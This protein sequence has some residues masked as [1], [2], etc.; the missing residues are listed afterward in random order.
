MRFKSL[1]AGPFIY[2]HKH[3]DEM[4]IIKEELE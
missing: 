4:D 2:G 1:S 3:I